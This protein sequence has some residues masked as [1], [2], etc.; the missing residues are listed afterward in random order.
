MINAELLNAYGT[1]QT[2]PFIRNVE[3]YRDPSDPRSLTCTS[4]NAIYCTTCTLCKTFYI[5]ETGRRLGD[6]FREHLRDVEKD[7]QNA[8]K[9]VSRHVNLPSH[10]K[11]HMAVYSLSLHQARTESSKTLEQK[12][13]FQIDTLYPRCLNERFSS[14]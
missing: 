6:R 11:Q 7:D 10:S 5:G 2:S 4:T 1:T 9:P 13:I 3:K 14:D 12:Y 8:S